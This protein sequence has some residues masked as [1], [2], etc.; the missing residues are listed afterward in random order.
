[1]SQ[2]T[3]IFE[4]ILFKH[5]THLPVWRVCGP[6]GEHL[7]DCHSPNLAGALAFCD[8]Y[9]H[10]KPRPSREYARCVVDMRDGCPYPVEVHHG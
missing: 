6:N 9:N 4:E 10:L 5:C 7:C 2:L 8:G 3:P 1:M